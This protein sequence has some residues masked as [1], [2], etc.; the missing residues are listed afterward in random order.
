MTGTDPTTLA[1]IYLIGPMGAGKST[2]GRELAAL[3]GRRFVDSDEEIVR[4]TGVEI[5]L[6]FELEGEGGFRSRESK[7]LEELTR[8]HGV[9]LATGG[10]AVL[11]PENR[12]R[13][14]SSG[15]V[16]YLTAAPRIL[17]KRTQRD[18]KRPLLQ[19]EDRLGRIRQLLGEREALYRE[20][21]DIVIDTGRQS[22]HR[23]V[24]N[25]C[26]ELELPCVK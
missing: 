7:L 4:R 20:L 5:D 6:I 9:V 16:V 17:A 15:S 22:A 10:G 19:T 2:I 13:L 21:A 14:R 23:I 12:K 11:D 25:I 24:E 1:N 3:T 26:R 18:R 8:L